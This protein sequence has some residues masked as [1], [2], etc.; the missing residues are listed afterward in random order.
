MTGRVDCGEIFLHFS[1]ILIFLFVF[2]KKNFKK[3]ETKAFYPLHF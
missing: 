3:A 2:K 1:S